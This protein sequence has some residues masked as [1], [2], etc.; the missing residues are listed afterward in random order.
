MAKSKPMVA[1]PT[2]VS[3]TLGPKPKKFLIVAFDVTKWSDRRIASLNME[4]WAQGEASSTISEQR[5]CRASRPG[6][7]W[8][9]G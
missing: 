9:A 1:K 2:D 8:A 4:V 7:G 6:H 3:F 5:P